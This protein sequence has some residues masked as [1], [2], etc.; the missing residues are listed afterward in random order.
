MSQLANFIHTPGV[1]CSSTCIQ[2]LVRF[3]GLEISEAMAFGLGAGLG[4]IFYQDKALSPSS[5]FNGRS[6]NLEENFYRC[7]GQPITWREEW[8]FDSLKISLKNGRPVLAKTFLAHLPY[9][10]PADFPGHGVIVTG[11]DESTGKLSIAD[12]LSESLFK[13]PVDDFH[14]A[15]AVDCPPFMKAYSWASAPSIHFKIEASLLQKAI[16]NMAEIM[17]QSDSKK[18]GL[19][20][21]ETA[22]DEI[23]G[24]AEDDDWQWHAR[25]AY[26][27][28]EKRGTGGAGFRPLYADFL[29]EASHYLPE[30]KL[31]KLE[32]AVRQSALLWQEMAQIFKQIYIDKNRNDF[33]QAAGLLAQINALETTL[34]TT[35][36]R[37]LK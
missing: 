6:T 37:H 13:I 16:V 32:E 21:M 2:D 14:K 7:I 18:E 8:D 5:R 11:F 12:S 20:A 26:Q 27:S 31:L 17:L 34:C 30:I 35:I 33:T 22:I 1:H 29:N 36:V 25:F 24:W 15:I 3:D 28:I 4:F 9:Y 23:P 10:D 19:T